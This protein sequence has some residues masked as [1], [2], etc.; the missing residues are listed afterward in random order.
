MNRDEALELVKQHISNKNLINH[1]LAVEAIMK[2]IAQKKNENIDKYTL[3]GLCHDIDF[4][5]TKDDLSKHGIKSAEMLEGKLDEE[6]LKCIRN[7]NELTGNRPE[8]DY[9]KALVAADAASGLVV[10]AALIM[11]SRKLNDV[12]LETLQNKFK[13]KDF[14]RNVSR[15]NIKLCEEI[16]FSLDEFLQLSLE[17]VQEI[18][19][20]IGL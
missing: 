17:A 10:S 16:G 20:E 2:I 1:M 3:A 14:A 7:H 15:D 11:P 19:Q 9:E 4:E 5:S 18:A 13:K 8:N 12:R 6:I